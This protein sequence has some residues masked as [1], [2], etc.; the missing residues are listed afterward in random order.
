L[1]PAQ[2]GLVIFN[3]ASSADFIFRCSTVAAI[4]AFLT[5]AKGF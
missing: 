3:I 4:L 2:A 1:K 5:V